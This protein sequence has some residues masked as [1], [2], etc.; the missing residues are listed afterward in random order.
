[1]KKRKTCLRFITLAIALVMILG[2]SALV[3]VYAQTAEPQA[4]NTVA[5]EP[6]VQPMA[7]TA[8]NTVSEEP[9]VQPTVQNTV[10]EIQEQPEVQNLASHKIVDDGNFRILI[11]SD[12]HYKLPT[13]SK[14]YGV[15]NADRVI[16][17]TFFIIV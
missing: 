8:Q 14:Y 5:E 10:Q 2:F 9:T 15:E 16:Y 1:M 3:G 4:Q 7:Q 11:T 17:D 6:T 13:E 12:I